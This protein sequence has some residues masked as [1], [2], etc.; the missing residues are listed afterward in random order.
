MKAITKKLSL[1]LMLSAVLFLSSCLESGSNSY[2]GNEEYSYI[3]SSQT[4]GTVYARTLAGHLITSPKISQ[5]SPGTAAF[6]TYQVT[7]ETERVT[8]EDNLV[9]YKVNLGAEPKSIDKTVLFQGSAPEMPVV[10]FESLMEP[11]FASND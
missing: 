6:L 5:L 2:I 9:V 11:L 8:L 7:E 10:K 1:L 4:T 3:T